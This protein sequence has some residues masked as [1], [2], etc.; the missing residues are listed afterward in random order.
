MK[1]KNNYLRYLGVFLLFLL[2]SSFL[3]CKKEKLVINMDKEFLQIDPKP[4]TSMYGGMWVLR[5]KLD[6]TANIVPGGDI[7]FKATYQIKSSTMKVVTDY[8][9][10]EFSVLSRTKIKEKEDAEAGDSTPLLSHTFIVTPLF[11]VLYGDVPL[12]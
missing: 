6:G 4:T 3:G 8:K 2:L 9:T 1:L 5:V 11:T 7:S 12:F 10:F